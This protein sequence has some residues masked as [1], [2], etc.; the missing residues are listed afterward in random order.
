MVIEEGKQEEDNSERKDEEEQ[1]HP[2]N[3]PINE[4]LQN[5]EE[6]QETV[7]Q[8]QEQPKIK[9]KPFSPSS[10]GAIGGKI[11]ESDYFQFDQEETTTNMTTKVSNLQGRL[12]PKRAAVMQNSGVAAL[13]KTDESSC[14]NFNADLMSSIMARKMSKNKTF[15]EV[16]LL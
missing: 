5:N 7:Q 3:E 13:V 1:Q 12:S 6:V 10:G 14:K 16:K 15:Y 9:A 11:R 4:Q 8:M 2:L